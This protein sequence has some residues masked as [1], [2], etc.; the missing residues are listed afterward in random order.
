MFNL[1]SFFSFNNKF[2]E[3]DDNFKLPEDF[4]SFFDK[5]IKPVFNDL[6]IER[7]EVL[8][9][10][11]TR[12]IKAFKIFI[13]FFC[14]LFFIHYFYPL[15]E[16]MPIVFGIMGIV[17]LVLIFYVYYNLKSYIDDT[18][19]KILSKLIKYFGEDF[20]Y[21]SN[22]YYNKNKNLSLTKNDLLKIN[23]L[24]SKIRSATRLNLEDY[25]K[26]THKNVKMEFFELETFKMQGS[27]KN[28]REVN[29]FNGLVLILDFPKKFKGNTL[30]KIDKGFLGNMTTF[31]YERV[32]LEDPVFEEQFEVYSSDQIEARYLLTTSF[33]Q[34]LLNLQKF[35]NAPIELNFSDNKLY[36]VIKTSHNF[37]E[38]KQ[39]INKPISNID[40]THNVRE[41]VLILKIIE[42]LKLNQNIGM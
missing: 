11:K 40:L 32:K 7:L 19:D 22:P 31:A 25:F 9:E 39:D 35:Y 10:L 5:K 18:K 14:L 20:I 6:E 15:N 3:F 37:F 34:R 24:S 17:F 26:G 21:I 33:M 8:A 30:I 28:R 2:T 16:I 42:E 41:F 38:F 23:I 1:K 4:Q 29:T 27:G 36:M 13:G 12:K